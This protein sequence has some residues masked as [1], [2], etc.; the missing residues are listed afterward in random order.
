MGDIQLTSSLNNDKTLV[1]D[2][3]GEKVY[4]ET[5]L[6]VRRFTLSEIDREIGMLQLRIDKL[7]A[8]KDKALAVVD[9]KPGVEDAKV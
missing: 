6:T 5:E 7:Q 1:F 2:E 8:K 9:V 4:E 3:S